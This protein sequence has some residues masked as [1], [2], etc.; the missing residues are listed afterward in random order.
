MSNEV[1]INVSG[2][3]VN[4]LAGSIT[5]HNSHVG[6]VVGQTA[7]DPA[8]LDGL[9]AA[10]ND[11]V[12]E[13]TDIQ[14]CA[15]TEASD[16]SEAVF[17]SLRAAAVTDAAPEQVEEATSSWK[18]LISKYGPKVQKAVLAFAETALLQYANNNPLVAG[19]ISALKTLDN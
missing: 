19:V 18:D 2:G 7:F 4:Q 17:Q 10:F 8:L 11:A 6:D 9:Q 3:Q 16:D 5:N 1:H 13:E 14:L 15:T 12:A